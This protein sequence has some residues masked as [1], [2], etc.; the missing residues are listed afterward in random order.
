M[1]NGPVAGLR[2]SKANATDFELW[3]RMATDNK[4]NANNSWNFALIDF[5]HDL[6]LLREGKSI[7]FQKASA[8]LDGCVKIYSSRVDSAAT[9]TGRLLSGLAASKYHKP[10][11]EENEQQE[12]E[13]DEEDIEEVGN[14]Q[15]K[16]NRV[17]EST[18]VS[19]FEQIRA[20]KMDFEFVVDPVFKK[21]L[22]DFDEGGSK[23]LLLNML[24]ID[25]T[26]RILF[27]TTS[28]SK[29][30]AIENNNETD[31]EKDFGINETDTPKDSPEVDISNLETLFFSNIEQLDNFRVCPSMGALEEIVAQGVDNTNILEQIEKQ[32][33]EHENQYY[34]DYDNAGSVFFDHDDYE[35]HDDAGGLGDNSMNV[36]L[37]RLFDETF[38]KEQK[39]KDGIEEIDD[40]PDYDLLAYFDQALRK[41]W[42]KGHE[43]WKVKHLIKKRNENVEARS[44]RNEVTT[45]KKDNLIIDFL[46]EEELD[47]DELFSESAAR[48]IIPK[49][50]WITHDKHCLPDDIHFTSRRLIHLFVKPLTILKTFNK[51]K[52]IPYEN[53][54]DNDHKAFA[55]E[56]FWSEKYKENEEL[57]R[58]RRLNDILREDLQELHKSYDQSFFQDTMRNFEDDNDYIDP[59]D[60]G[61]LNDLFNGY[62]SQLVTSQSHIKPTHINFSKVAKRVDVKLL[63]NNLWEIL[64]SDSI[65]NSEG[66]N[67]D[68]IEKFENYMESQIN[69]QGIEEEDSVDGTTK[70]STI[71]NNLTTK[72]SK[73]EKNDLSTSFCFICLLHL[74]NENGFTIENNNDTSDLIIKNMTIDDDINDTHI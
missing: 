32:K 54:K 14:K 5:F 31:I 38:Q 72:Y 2:P 57:E 59:M 35:H 66:L 64:K 22:S 71:L 58:S 13:D 74:A 6:S 40:I 4:I 62:G 39:V 45:R 56:E 47:E 20:K 60:G 17:L 73:E 25:S 70:F 51:R 65:F 34:D 30:L 18:L 33:S 55:D 8:T 7:N 68:K 3:I 16:R 26:E 44:Q 23:S 67:N 11:V 63:K 52:I 69:P 37:Q 43:H 46:S 21:A 41:N 50:Q 24:S 29:T 42:T 36:T 9:E 61:D 1:E 10:N 49:H 15:R 19:S 12:E 28:D 53:K 48:I 27:D